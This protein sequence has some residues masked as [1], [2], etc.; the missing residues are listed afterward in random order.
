VLSTCAQARKVELDLNVEAALVTAVALVP[1]SVY[2]LLLVC[3]LGLNA[4][5]SA[6]FAAEVLQALF[7]PEQV[8]RGISGGVLRLNKA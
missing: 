5:S 4:W 6:G 8:F 3:V 1:H 7:D 2:V